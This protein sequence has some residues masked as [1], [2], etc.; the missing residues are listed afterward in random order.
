MSAAVRFDG[1][2]NLITLG[3]ARLVFHCHHYNV[4]LQRTVEDALGYEA[5][6]DVQRDA[7]A[8]TA[9]LMLTAPFSAHD[10]LASRLA[11]AKDLFAQTGFGLA[12]VSEL[13]AEGG[14]VVL[15]TSHYAVGYTSKWGSMPRPAC[16]FASG[17]W[18]GAL[19]AATGHAPERVASIEVECAA[20]GASSCVI[21]IEVR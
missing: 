20:T 6:R 7:A 9:R 21:E 12:D 2:R 14:R 11:F 17:Y 8:E 4:S 1:T 10:S 3:D 18:A 13:T 19:T 15:L 5:A 16:H